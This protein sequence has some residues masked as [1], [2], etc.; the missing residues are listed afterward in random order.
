M[1]STAT[2]CQCVLTLAASF[3]FLATA[4]AQSAGASTTAPTAHQTVPALFLSDIHLDPFA[5]PAK[6]AKL[7]AAPADE[8]PSILAAPA[9]PTQAKDFAELISACQSKG[10]DTSWTLWQSSL[11]AIHD[12]AS[13]ALFVTISGDLLAHNFD[14]KFQKML[15]AAKPADYL[16]FAEKTV[17]AI[18]DTLRAA[19][20]GVP[21]YVAM[22]NNDTGCR[23]N[24]LDATHDAFLG[25][26][27][28]IVAEALP[29]E[30]RATVLRD[31]A[32]GGYYDVPLPYAVPKT[33]L[34]V[35]D[36]LYF[37]A[38]YTT[39]AG[40]GDASP[41]AAQ[42][43]WLASQLASARQHKEHV[44]VMGHIPPGVDLYGSAKKNVNVCGAAGPQ[45]YLASESLA[46]LLVQ[47]ADIVRLAIF[48]HTHADEMRLL[49]PESVSANTSVQSAQGVPLKII[50]PITPIS[51]NRSSITLASI[52]PTTA[53][54]VDYSVFTASNLTGIQA[55]WSK[56]YSFSTTY[57][58]PAYDAVSLA[59]L[60]PELQADHG[61]KTAASQAYVSNFFRGDVVPLFR[62]AWP[63]Y[64]CSLQHDSMAS[65]NAC[66][67]SGTK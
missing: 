6:V 65:F 9:S 28:K 43:A 12:N 61:I 3:T 30:D 53:T 36:D 60:I 35:I 7:N 47:Y 14:C 11:K 27:A 62:L 32:D 19:L 57:H 29:S 55:T 46:D 31:F 4:H 59:H 64:A 58:V 10:V 54:M 45:M 52:D 41:A 23:D 20:P 34:L 63:M 49:T 15:P 33:R 8:W 38:K 50:A 39:C 1:T 67:C 13:Q 5:D 22:G 18:V 37:S 25:L 66:A 26:I 51:L 21:V 56:E 17:R 2:L 48:G 42:L 16:A 44:W 40:K 24:S